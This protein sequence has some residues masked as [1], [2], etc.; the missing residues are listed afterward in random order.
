M[1]QRSFDG[2]IAASQRLLGR[3]AG[4]IVYRFDRPARTAADNNR[5]ASCFRPLPRLSKMNHCPAWRTA[6]TAW[7]LRSD[8]TLTTTRRRSSGAKPASSRTAYF[9]TAYCLQSPTPAARALS[10][11]VHAV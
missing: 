7:L 5:E 3:T 1:H 10:G 9:K 8:L 4:Q 6:T 2:L 11:D